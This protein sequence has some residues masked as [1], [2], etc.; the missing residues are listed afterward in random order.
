MGWQSG[1]SYYEVIVERALIQLSAFSPLCAD[2]RYNHSTWFSGKLRYDFVLGMSIPSI[3]VSP[4]LIE[5]HGEQHYSWYH[6]NGNDAKKERL[7]LEHG[8][9]FLVIPYSD[10]Y[11][12]SDKLLDLI[13]GFL[14]AQ[15]H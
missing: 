6:D 5:V 9:P 10:A 11:E 13:Q 12:V 1:K 3:C 15:P 8:C 4:Y 14:A 2:Y 7:A